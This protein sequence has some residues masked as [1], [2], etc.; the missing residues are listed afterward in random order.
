MW[1]CELRTIEL[2]AFIGLTKLTELFLT[3][4]DINEIIQGTFENMGN[5]ENLA[6]QSN[7]IEHSD[8]DVFSGLVNRNK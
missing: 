7:I 5:L 6:L 4:T 2:G 1:E 3:Y 8:R